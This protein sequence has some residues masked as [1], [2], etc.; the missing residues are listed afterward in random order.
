MEEIVLARG[1][2]P[3]AWS[4][5]KPLFKEGQEQPSEEELVE[6]ARLAISG[7]SIPAPPKPKTT[8]KSSVTKRRK[9]GGK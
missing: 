3:V 2:E 5:S 8:K 4:F 7:D 1:Y 9:K 6:I